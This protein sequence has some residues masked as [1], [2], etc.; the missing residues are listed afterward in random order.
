M[1]KVLKQTR[2]MYQK[3]LL[4]EMGLFSFLIAVSFSCDIAF[5]V[6]IT[7]GVMC[8]FLPHCLFVAL[9]VFPYQQSPIGSKVKKLYYGEALKVVFT[10]VLIAT[11]FMAYE[12]INGV[13]FVGYILGLLLNSIIPLCLKAKSSRS[14]NLFK[15]H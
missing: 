8:A 15:F 4:L 3:A 10:I 14:S 11:V 12:E 6:F 13:F 2:K 7:L 1:S 9:V 5:G